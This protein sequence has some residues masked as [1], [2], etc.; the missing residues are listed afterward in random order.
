MRK[1]LQIHTHRLLCR[2]YNLAL[3]RV[4]SIKL[5]PTLLQVRHRH[6]LLLRSLGA[7]QAKTMFRLK[8]SSAVSATQTSIQYVTSGVALSTLVSPDM[9][10]LVVSPRSGLQSPSSSPATR[11]EER[12][13]GKECR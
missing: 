13:V 3:N 10:S 9:K 7:I 11:S 6:L 1:L 2:R 4:V 5:R 12:R 8:S